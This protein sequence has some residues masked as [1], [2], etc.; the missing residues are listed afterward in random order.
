MFPLSTYLTVENIPTK[1]GCKCE[2]YGN[3]K[4]R[5]WGIFS[6]IREQTDWNE[7]RSDDEESESQ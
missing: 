7:K 6:V 1:R 2:R 5:F 3:E 4:R